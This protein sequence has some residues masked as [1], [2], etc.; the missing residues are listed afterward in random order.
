VRKNWSKK[1][2]L[3][4]LREEVAA[5][6]AEYIPFSSV[7]LVS[8]DPEE[9]RWRNQFSMEGQVNYN[10]VLRGWIGFSK[11]ELKAFL[12]ADLYIVAPK[13]PLV[14]LAEQAE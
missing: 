4:R 11:W 10:G 9:R 1:R 6:L 12:K 3:R 7:G 8:P 5:R 2:E 13:S 14:V